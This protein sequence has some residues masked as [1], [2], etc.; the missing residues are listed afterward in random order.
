MAKRARVAAAVGLLAAL[1]LLTFFAVNKDRL[2]EEWYLRRLDVGDET[3]Q[4]AARAALLE[5]ASV[6]AVPILLRRG[7]EFLSG[8]D[9]G[10]N[11]DHQCVRGILSR[12]DRAGFERLAR[13]LDE[14]N[15]Q[16]FL[17]ALLLHGDTKSSEAQR[18]YFLGASLESRNAGIRRYAAER[19]A[20]LGPDARMMTSRLE[21][22]RWDPIPGVRFWAKIALRN[23]GESS[24]GD[25]FDGR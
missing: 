22:I 12:L 8:A 5:L 24:T 23:V 7:V 15:P 9:E 20:H 3:A 13:R 2:V 11:P 4:E 17:R 1:T 10:E 25:L 18:A 6:P 16:A 14:G 19:L 21:K